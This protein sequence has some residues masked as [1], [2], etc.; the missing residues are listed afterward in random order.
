MNRSIKRLALAAVA[1]ALFCVGPA[2]SVASAASAEWTPQGTMKQQG[3][4]EFRLNGGSPVTCQIS[5]QGTASSNTF[6][7][8]I[9]PSP[10]SNGKTITLS[11]IQAGQNEGGAYSV[12]LLGNPTWKTAAPW[13]GYWT[14]EQFVTVLPF[15]NGSGSKMSTFSFS[16]TYLGPWLNPS[17]PNGKVTA[18]GTITATTGT[19]GLITLK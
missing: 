12:R 10:C 7:A 6:S 9:A 16:N 13:G 14:Q 11:L 3:S 1:A 19:G 2:S 15:V 5:T 8:N 4:I 17:G 18:T